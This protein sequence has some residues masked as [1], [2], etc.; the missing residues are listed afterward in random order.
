MA[1]VDPSRRPRT[2]TEQLSEIGLDRRGLIAM[3]SLPKYWDAKSASSGR[4]ALVAHPQTGFDR[5][6]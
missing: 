1:V 2:K 4:A 6:V 3:A 5:E